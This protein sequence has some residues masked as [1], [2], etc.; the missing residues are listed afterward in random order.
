MRRG[1]RFKVLTRD[2]YTCR[3]CGAKAPDAKLHVDH[4]TPKSAGG[5]N[6]LWNLI[7]AC[8]PCNQ[9]KAAMLIEQAAGDLTEP[10]YRSAHAELLRKS[11]EHFLYDMAGIQN[12]WEDFSG[13]KPTRREIVFLGELVIPYGYSRVFRAMEMIAKEQEWSPE[14]GFFVD[15]DLFEIRQTLSRWRREGVA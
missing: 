11:R 3:Y 14:D 13:R 6:D 12:E 4:I 9:G 10:E 15:F 5:T 1:L 2:N 7:T 8:Q